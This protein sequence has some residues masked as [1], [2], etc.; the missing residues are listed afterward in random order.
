[1]SDSGTP[2]TKF[3]I[4]DFSA[5]LLDI[6][7]LLALIARFEAQVNPYIP[8]VNNVLDGWKVSR[9]V[10]NDRRHL[11]RL[12]P[13]NP[14]QL[15]SLA[16]KCYKDTP[17]LAERVYYTLL[18]IYDSGVHISARPFY[19]SHS[20]P[21]LPGGVLVYE[22]IH[23]EP[24]QAP[25]GIENEEMWHRVMT[26]LGVPKNVPFA[27]HANVIPIQQSIQHPAHV[28]SLLQ[29]T[30]ADLQTHTST[31]PLLGDLA[32]LVQKAEQTIVPEWSHLPKIGL[33]QLDPDY[34]HYIWDGFHLRV[35]GWSKVDWADSAYDLALMAA[36]PHYED[37]PLSHWVWFRWEYARLSHEDAVIS[38]ATT[39][40]HLLYIYWAIKLTFQ[41]ETTS[42]E[43]QKVKLL[44]QRERYLK[45]ARQA[46][47]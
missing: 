17:A 5:E 2:P 36:D 13:P 18:A 32:G 23:G 37:L 28:I 8:E 39:Y 10:R 34:R 24:L 29:E 27:Q 30:L 41:A 26:L 6:P 4:Y 31:H 25:P 47:G 22:W 44:K 46:F 16:I 19:F 20:H 42:D 3:D 11:Y 14:E 45:K 15:P 21:H 7:A 38:R 12:D 43:R 33:S 35:T 1:M 40:T 9:L